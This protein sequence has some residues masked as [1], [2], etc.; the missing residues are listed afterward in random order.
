MS[1]S[2]AAPTKDGAAARRPRCPTIRCLIRWV[3]LL[4]LQRQGALTDSVESKIERG[5][6]G[7]LASA[8]LQTMIGAAR[9]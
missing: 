8:E 2:W 1:I 9:L 5:G 6:R 4:A 7:L 3:A